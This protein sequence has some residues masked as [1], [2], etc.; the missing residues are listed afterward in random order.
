[1]IAPSFA[2]AAALAVLLGLYMLDNLSNAMYN[3][4]YVLAA[5][6]LAGMASSRPNRDTEDEDDEYEASFV[7][8]ACVRRAS[9]QAAGREEASMS[10]DREGTGGV[11]ETRVQ[12]EART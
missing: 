9:S 5:G 12:S 6:G 11:L 2:P 1:M 8:A 10:S 7:S 3:P 4:I